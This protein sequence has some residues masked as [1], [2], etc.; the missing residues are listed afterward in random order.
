[1][2]ASTIDF[3]SLQE[4]GRWKVE[5][6]CSMDSENRLT[7]DL[8]PIGTLVQERRETIDPTS[9]GNKLINYV[10]LEHIQ[11]LTGELVNFSPRS[12]TMVKSRSKVYCENDVLY[13]RLRPSLNKVWL[14]N[15]EANN[16][17]CSTE[18]FVLIAD[19]KKIRPLILRYLLSSHYVQRH[20]ERLQTGTA[21][22]RMNLDDL[23][24]IKVPVPE[25]SLQKHIESELTK[26]FG[27]L[28][29]IRQKM[30][31]LPETIMQDF[32]LKV[33]AA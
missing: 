1:M 15:G 2:W 12:A 20:A 4:R 10:G 8:V 9:L 26:Q 24:E 33:E 6:F 21:L 5:F 14:A 11:S 27:E 19:E 28:L 29:K 23:L 18:F 30:Q 31:T 16:G 22:P 32:L 7:Q 13:G 17:I 3:K 25:L